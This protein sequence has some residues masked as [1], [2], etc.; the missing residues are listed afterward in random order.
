MSKLVLVDAISTFYIRYAVE[1]SDNEV[2]QAIDE[3]RLGKVQ[4]E[5]SQKH[6]GESVISQRVVSVDEYLE[7]FD[8]DN[9]H[10]K[11]WTPEQKMRYIHVHD[12][13]DE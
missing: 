5:F 3:V 1:T 7:L 12:S 10:L 9:Y 6:L 4:D 13:N 2:D 8:K 11:S